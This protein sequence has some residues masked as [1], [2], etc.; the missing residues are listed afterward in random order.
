MNGFNYVSSPEYPHKL[1]SMPREQK[2]EMCLALRRHM[3]AIFPDLSLLYKAT[4]SG[5]PTH[6]A[7]GIIQPVL[8]ESEKFSRV[9]L[10]THRFTEWYP[11]FHE[12]ERLDSLH[13]ATI[14]CYAYIY[15]GYPLRRAFDRG[16]PLPDYLW[17]FLPQTWYEIFLQQQQEVDL[18]QQQFQQQQGETK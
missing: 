9:Q 18:L 2:R 14:E 3:L 5:E 15:Y 12:S 13:K 16:Q 11:F 17:Y 6:V 1:H 4:K 10:P 7:Y 8:T